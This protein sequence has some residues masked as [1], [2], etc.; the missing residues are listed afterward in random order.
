MIGRTAK[1]SLAILV[2]LAGPLIGTAAAD[3]P[4]RSPGGQTLSVPDE[5]LDLGDVYYVSS[6]AGTQLTWTA[7]APLMRIVASCNRVVGYFVA[8]FDLEEGKPPLLAGAIRIPVASLRT[9]I[10]GLDGELHGE[11]VLNAAEYPEITLE[12]ASVSDSKLVSGEGGKQLYTLSAACRFTVKDK[13][14]ELELPLRITLMPFTWQTM[15]LGM[16]DALVLRTEFDVKRADLPI[17]PPPR[18]NPDFHPESDRLVLFLVCNAMSPE[19]NLSPD[20][21]HE[22][23]RKQLQFITLLRDFND[24]EKGYEFGRSFMKEIWDDAQ[25]L[26]RLTSV[27]LDEAGIETRELAFALKAAQRA[28]DLTESKAPELLSTLASVYYEKGELATAIKWARQAV[29]NLG[30]AAPPLAGQ[31]RETLQRYESHAEKLN[32]HQ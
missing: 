25:A 16:G 19:R 22:V 2:L 17:Q 20:I 26:N 6:G 15:Q 23:Y 13:T 12:I 3:V 10:A 30:D 5:Q 11:S 29:E 27:L 9:G 14:L 31:I 1:T 28:N 18:P 24:A 32:E 21:T 8:P 4:P 7:D